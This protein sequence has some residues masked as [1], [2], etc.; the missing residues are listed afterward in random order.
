MFLMV[1]APA[2]QEETLIFL[3][4]ALCWAQWQQGQ[5]SGVLG[6]ITAHKKLPV[7]GESTLLPYAM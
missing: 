7:Y 6:A 2:G 1:H 4:L 3:G 5:K